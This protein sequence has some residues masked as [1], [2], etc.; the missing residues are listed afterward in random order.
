M[1]AG[2]YL[3]P[4]EMDAFRLRLASYASTYPDSD[5][6]DNARSYAGSGRIFT[7]ENAA[8]V[9]DALRSWE[10]RLNAPRFDPGRCPPGLDEHTWQLAV[11]LRE[12]IELSGWPCKSLRIAYAELG[13]LIARDGLRQDHAPWRD[14]PGAPGWHRMLA[15]VIIHYTDHEVSEQNAWYAAEDLAQPGTVARIRG[16]LADQ[17]KLGVLDQHAQP[18]NTRVPTPERRAQVASYI[19][20]RKKVKP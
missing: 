15:A 20:S 12:R 13:R 1:T 5:F 4:A 14:D 11:L 19:Q 9:D 7:R 10:T 3:R 18:A 16:Y 8:K 6:L 2:R 17:A